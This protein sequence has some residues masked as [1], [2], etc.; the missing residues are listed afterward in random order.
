MKKLE[1]FIRYWKVG[2]LLHIVAFLAF[3]IALLSYLVLQNL[4]TDVSISVWIAWLII[5]ICFFN[6]AILAELDGYSRYQNYKQIKDQIYLNGYQERLLKPL[7][8]SSCQRAAAMLAGNELGI[9]NKISSY[10]FNRGYRW[11]HIIP[12][13][14]FSNPLLFFTIYFWRSTFFTPYYKTKFNYDVLLISDSYTTVPK[15]S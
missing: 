11:Y 8:K 12:D 15:E 5:F 13:F 2:K 14:V 7:S 1:S 9:E 4:N 3:F 6:M 10:F